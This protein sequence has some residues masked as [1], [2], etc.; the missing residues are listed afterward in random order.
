MSHT[1]KALVLHC[2]DFRFRKSLTNFLESKFGDSYDL[3]S[4]AGSVKSLVSDNPEGNFIL[5]QMKISDKLHKPQTILLIQHEDCGAYGGSA[6][7]GNDFSKEQEYQNAELEKAEALLK[8]Q[9]SQPVETYL[10][11]LA[12]EIVIL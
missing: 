4:V 9:F 6:A 7:F 10:A 3:V 8:Q 2:I 11:K 5:E 1:C 12:G